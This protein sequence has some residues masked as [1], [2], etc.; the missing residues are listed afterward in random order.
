MAQN[1]LW[2]EDE[3][4]LAYWVYKCLGFVHLSP[5]DPT[6][7]R[8]SEVLIDLPIHP[9]DQRL[10]SFR[11]PGGVRRRIGDLR[12]LDQGKDVAGH[13]AYREVVEAYQDHPAELDQRANQILSGYGVRWE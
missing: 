6:I 9:D 10:P 8:L 2:T 7:K 4:I 1:P 3:L 11:D 12:A 13:H 5:E